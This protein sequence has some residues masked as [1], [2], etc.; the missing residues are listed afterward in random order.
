LTK[1]SEHFS[2][3]KHDSKID[4]APRAR[5]RNASS[6]PDGTINTRPQQRMNNKNPLNQ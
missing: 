6:R 4:G 5:A 1:N 2:K 3:Q